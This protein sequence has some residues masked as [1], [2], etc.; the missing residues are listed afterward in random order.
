VNRVPF[1]PNDPVYGGKLNANRRYRGLPLGR[2]QP[3]G[4]TGFLTV[5][6]GQLMRLRHNPFFAYMEERMVDEIDPLL[7]RGPGVNP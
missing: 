1:P 4:E 3:R 7:K 5:S 2:L 6:L